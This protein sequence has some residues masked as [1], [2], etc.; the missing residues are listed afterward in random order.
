MT[1]MSTASTVS[2]NQPKSLIGF[3]IDDC[4]AL[5]AS[6]VQGAWGAVRSRGNIRSGCRRVRL[7]LEAP[8]VSGVDGAFRSECESSTMNAEESIRS[9]CEAGISICRDAGV[10]ALE[11]F[12]NVDALSVEV[13]APQ[14]LVSEADRNVELFI[15]Q[16][17]MK[18]FPNDGIVGEE[19]PAAA[20]STPYTWIIDPIDGTSNFV[21]GI[22][23]WTVVLACHMDKHTV[24]GIVHDPVHDELF[25]CMRG[26][27]A[28]LN[29]KPAR[30]AEAKSFADGL[31]G[32][33]TATKRSKNPAPGFIEQLKSQGGE[34][35]KNG[36]GALCL[37]QVAAGRF[38]GYF[39]DNMNSWDCVAG[40]LLVREAG[41]RAM[42]LDESGSPTAAGRVVAGAPAIAE[43]ILKIA[44]NF[45]ADA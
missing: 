20:G 41:G 7:R 45:D 29:G 16:E 38:I 5:S 21:R 40:L 28:F 3:H 36:S 10:Q 1:P 37:A 30:V 14:D 23:V 33:G 43:K 18:R 39:E 44:E 2:Q 4:N 15:R 31:V 35:V 9:R 27:G 42:D 12:R 32:L 25:H 34:F 17:I 19:H 6:L 8:A 26:G 13:K 11:Y 22:P 24:V